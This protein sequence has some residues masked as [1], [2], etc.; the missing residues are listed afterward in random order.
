MF[1]LMGFF[2]ILCVSGNDT[3]NAADQ[4]NEQNAVQTLQN[5]NLQPVVVVIVVALQHWFLA[6]IRTLRK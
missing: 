5:T 6:D 1:S 2:V 4:G 3:L